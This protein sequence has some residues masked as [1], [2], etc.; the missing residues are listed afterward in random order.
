VEAKPRVGTPSHYL[1]VIKAFYRN[2]NGVVLI[3]DVFSP[4][5]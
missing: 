1:R 5:R 2:S 4:D 3:F